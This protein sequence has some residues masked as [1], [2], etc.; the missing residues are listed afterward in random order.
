MSEFL[1]FA[2]QYKVK[3]SAAVKSFIATAKKQAEAIRDD[4]L[5]RRSWAKKEGTGYSITLGKIEGNYSLPDKDAAFDFISRAVRAA[6]D[7][8]E[9]I[10]LIEETD[11]TVEVPKSKK[12]R[13]AVRL[14]EERKG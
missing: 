11:G 6:R 13:R 4:K 1:K 3:E 8:Q 12:Q 7:D 5:N 10:S 2:E 9:F 14:T